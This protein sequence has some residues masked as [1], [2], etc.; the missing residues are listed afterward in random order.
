[1]KMLRNKYNVCK[2]NRAQGSLETSS[3]G[4]A[5]KSTVEIFIYLLKIME[6]AVCEIMDPSRK[7]LKK[8]K[9]VCM[10]MYQEG[11]KSE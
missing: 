4:Q 8:I 7:E 10:E 1:M 9:S 5:D 11:K 6:R 2:K 3:Q